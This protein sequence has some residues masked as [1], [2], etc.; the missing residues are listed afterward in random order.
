M[1]KSPIPGVADDLADFPNPR[2]GNRF[3]GRICHF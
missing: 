1:D 2:L 3:S